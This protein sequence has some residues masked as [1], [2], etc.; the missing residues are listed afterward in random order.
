MK[1]VIIAGIIVAFVL[2][3]TLIFVPII[4]N[5]S[6]SAAAET[7]DTAADVSAGSES[8]TADVSGAAGTETD[9]ITDASSD[10]GE[11]VHITETDPETDGTESESVSETEE[12][13][14]EELT[15]EAE[16]TTEKEDPTETETETEPAATEKETESE[17][18]TEKETTKAPETTAEQTV[19]ITTQEVK[20]LDPEKKYVAFTFDDG[21]DATRSKL[22][23]D[24]MLEYGG[25]CTFFVIG[26]CIYGDREKG[27]KYAYE[28]GMEIALHCWSHEWY[29]TKNPEKYHDEVYKGAEAIKNSIGIWPTLMRPPGGNITESQYK[30]SEFPVILWSI[31]TNDWRYKRLKTDSAADTQEKINT[32]VNNALYDK[33]GKF[34]VKNGDIILMHEIYENSYDAFCIIIEELHNR[35]FEFVTVSELLQNPAPGYKYYS[36]TYKK[37]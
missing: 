23:T 28:H 2:L 31:D 11:T 24:K 34:N 22:I 21:P 4:V 15:T 13:A 17:T 19:P 9:V 16:I 8:L 32:I 3:A 5:N 33:N 30:N 20:P 14:T 26:N 25:K 7:A 18:E 36:A 10:T 27:M 6:R 29:Y 37:G 35:G 1:K 12:T